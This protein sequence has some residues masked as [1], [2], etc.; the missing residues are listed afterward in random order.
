MARPAEPTGI[1]AGPSLTA[2]S[3]ISSSSAS[4]VASTVTI[5][6]PAAT[7][8]AMRSETFAASSSPTSR[9]MLPG[10]NADARAVCT[11]VTGSRPIEV[12]STATPFTST[13]PTWSV[14]P[15]PGYAGQTIAN[16]F[17]S[18]LPCSPARAPAHAVSAPR[19]WASTEPRIVESIFTNNR[20]IPASRRVATADTVASRAD[21]RGW[22]RASVTMAITPPGFTA[23]ES[24]RARLA[25]QP[26]SA[27]C[28]AESP[29]PVRSS[30]MM[31]MVTRVLRRG[32]ACSILGCWAALVTLRGA[33]CWSGRLS[34][35]CP[36]RPGRPGRSRGRGNRR[37]SPH[38][39]CRRPPSAHPGA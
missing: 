23:T 30:A 5:S 19:I 16:G 17:C 24:V 36:A 14:R 35:R 1:A 11:G 25:C 3:A 8:A 6:M 32:G 12:S 39:C 37:G 20:S 34:G 38:P 33:R 27:N 31:P 13:R 26:A 2:A 21:S 4:V 10:I 22:A 29:A 9:F 18:A 28:T 15:M 7:R